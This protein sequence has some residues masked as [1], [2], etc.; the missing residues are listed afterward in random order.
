VSDIHII[1]KFAS[2]ITAKNTGFAAGLSWL[3][4]VIPAFG[5]KTDNLAAWLA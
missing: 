1:G 4:S 5:G 2:S 3:I